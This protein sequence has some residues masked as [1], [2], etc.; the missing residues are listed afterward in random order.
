MTN[1]L[2]RRTLALGLG[3]SALLP[4]VSWAARDDTYSEPEIVEAAERFFGAGAQG[5][6]AVVNHVF[7]DLGRP[8]GYVE[9]QEG[10]GAIGI[11]L[12]YGDGNL[13][14]KGL[15]GL[16]H[17]FWRGPSVGFDTGGNAS[18]VFTLVYGMRRP[19]QIF[20]R[21]PGVDGSAYFVGGVG[22]N[23]QRSGRITLAPMRA[24]VGFRLGANVG[25]LHY[26]RRRGINPF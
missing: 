25:Y 22:V 7:S 8:N 11:G 18:K 21:F 5:I 19:D 23:Y 20:H 13:H 1:N 16:T 6:A 15:P 26:S 3:A 24:G 2:S 17:T 4:S 10:S 9:G 12:R 14:I